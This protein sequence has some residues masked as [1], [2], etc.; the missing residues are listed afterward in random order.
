M[1]TAPIVHST[2]LSDWVNAYYDEQSQ[3]LKTA[4]LELDERKS[5]RDCS[6]VLFKLVKMDESVF[7]EFVYRIVLGNWWWCVRLREV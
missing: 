2:V 7:H 5:L 3:V 1:L 4:K 6:K